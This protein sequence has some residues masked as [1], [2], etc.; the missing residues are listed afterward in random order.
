MTDDEALFSSW[1]TFFVVAGV[2]IF[3]VTGNIAGCNSYETYMAS[4]EAASQAVLEKAKAEKTQIEAKAISSLVEKYGATPMEA[5]CAIKGWDENVGDVRAQERTAL[6]C[7]MIAAG[8][9]ASV[10]GE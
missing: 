1:K 3:L 6:I 5:R 10:V 4:K 8:K 2:T 7:A 9:K